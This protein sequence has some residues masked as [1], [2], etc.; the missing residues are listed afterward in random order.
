[1]C[2]NGP[3]LRLDTLFLKETLLLPSLHHVGLQEKVFKRLVVGANY[4]NF[5]SKVAPP[6]IQTLNDGLYFP[7]NRIVSLLSLSSIH[8]K[9]LTGETSYL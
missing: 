5:P 4:K 1:M 9:I 8:E 2:S 7:I 6:I 3:K